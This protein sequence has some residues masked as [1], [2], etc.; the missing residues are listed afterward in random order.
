[1]YRSL[2]YQILDQSSTLY[3]HFSKVLKEKYAELVNDGDG[4]AR[5]CDPWGL[6]ELEQ[7][8][9]SIFI[10][11]SKDIKLSITLFLDALDEW[12]EDEWDNILTLFRKCIEYSEST[13]IEFSIYFSSR[14]NPE[15]KVEECQSLIL[16]D[17][18]YGDIA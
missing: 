10:F 11:K 9:T 6:Q 14:H 4:A 1:M 17:G 12:Q 16:Q 18:N 3:C 2:L 13:D 5:A 7:I 15:I 8:F